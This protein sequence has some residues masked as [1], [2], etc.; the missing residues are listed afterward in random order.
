MTICPPGGCQG[1]AVL[2]C[3]G[4]LT[5]ACPVGSLPL[6]TT[7]VHLW[8]DLQG[9]GHLG[10][11]VQSWGGLS[12]ARAH[13]GAPT[14]PMRCPRPLLFLT[15]ASFSPSPLSAC[16]QWPPCWEVIPKVLTQNTLCQEFARCCFFLNQCCQSS[17]RGAWGRKQTFHTF[18]QG[19]SHR[20]QPNGFL[21]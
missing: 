14:S 16:S 11:Q 6:G 15:L 3:T 9:F 10:S 12:L 18:R 2:S 19:C 4:A 20:D 17:V 21:L 7:S 13:S 1:Q 8:P 5:Q